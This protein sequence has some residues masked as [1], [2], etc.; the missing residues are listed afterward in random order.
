M[1]HI[2]HANCLDVLR[3]MPNCSVDALGT[4]PPYG[5]NFMNKE[6]DRGIPGPE[7]WSEILRVLKPGS[8]GVVM[9][10]PRLYHRLV[11]VIEDSGFEI[12]DCIMWLY[13]SGFPKSHNVALGIDKYLGHKNRGQVIPTA[14]TK[15]ACGTPLKGNIVE[16][17]KPQTE[18][19]EPWIGYGTALKP[20]YEP[21]VLI[22]KPLEGTVAQNVLK[23]GVGALNI[24]DTRIGNEEITINRFKDGMKPFGKGAGHDYEATSVKGRW[25]ANICHDGSEEVLENFPKEKVEEKIRVVKGTHSD[26]QNYGKFNKNKI[27]SFVTGGSA[28]RFF[29]CSKANVKEREAGLHKRDPINV[30]DGR[31]KPTDNPYQRGKTKR[32]NTHVTVKPI[33]LCRWLTSLVC[34]S[35]GFIIDPF[36]GS[37]SFGCA[38]T[39]EGFDWIGMEIEQESAEIAEKRIQYWRKYATKTETENK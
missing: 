2:I 3:D 26:N 13:G 35:G 24:N 17:Y 19:A 32:R 11:C 21:I 22:R 39:L 5:L 9:G 29:Y 37:G 1:Q 28:A 16:D 33:S 10:A 20:A 4:D 34:P 31:S 12:R 8:C 23:Y 25:P 14:S 15:Q 38:A 7:Y 6:W 36:A 30:T 18:E 27:K